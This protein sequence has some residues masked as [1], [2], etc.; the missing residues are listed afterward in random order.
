MALKKLK[1]GSQRGMKVNFRS[2]PLI[3]SVTERVGLLNSKRKIRVISVPPP[4]QP[5]VGKVTYFVQVKDPVDFPVLE[6]SR[7][8]DAECFVR[9]IQKSKTQMGMQIKA[10]ILRQEVTGEGYH[11]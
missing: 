6:F 3:A 7:K 8:K 4:R 2:M 1:K 5:R 9:T 11:L 10:A